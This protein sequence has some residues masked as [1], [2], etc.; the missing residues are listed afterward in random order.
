MK[1]EALNGQRFL[2]GPLKPL[3]LGY[4]RFLSLLLLTLSSFFKVGVMPV[5]LELEQFFHHP[6]AL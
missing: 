3:R 1:E 4:V 6:S 2:K 5:A